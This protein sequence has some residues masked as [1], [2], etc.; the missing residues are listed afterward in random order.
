VFDCISVVKERYGV[1]AGERK[2]KS[3]LKIF[4]VG[5]PT[6]TLAPG[7]TLR[8]VDAARFRVIYTMD[9][10]VTQATL[11]SHSVGYAGFFADIATA[12]D[13]AGKIEL[14]LYWPGED[15]WLGKNFAVALGG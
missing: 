15:R 7:M 8:V 3:G 14:T 9:G 2:F 12:G 5:R 4:Q 6:A 11:E 13:K 1:A 10:W